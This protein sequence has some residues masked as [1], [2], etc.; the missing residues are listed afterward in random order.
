MELKPVATV[1]YHSPQA[2]WAFA[3]RI[4]VRA[5]TEGPSGCGKTSLIV[6]MLTQLF[7]NKGSIFERVYVFSPSNFV[8]PAWTTIR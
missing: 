5:I 7:V 4:P 6:Q 3:P 1:E 8:D 2:K